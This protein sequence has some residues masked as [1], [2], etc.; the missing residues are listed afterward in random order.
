MSEVPTMLASK[1]LYLDRSSAASAIRHN[2]LDPDLHEILLDIT[3][4]TSL[5]KNLPTDL[6]IELTTFQEMLVS[7]CSRLIRFHP[8]QSLKQKSDIEAVYH[9]GL[10]IFMMT[11]FL[12]YDHRRILQYELVSLRLKDVLDRGLDEVDDDLVLWLLL[13]GGIWISSGTDRFWLTSR[14]M[15]LARRLGLNSWA[16]VHGYVSTFPW[17]STLHDQPGRAVWNSVYEGS[18]MPRPTEFHN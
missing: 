5:V 17:I 11:L 8:L 6:T 12:Q 14:I 15:E 2:G 4:V 13:I 16:D 7:I 10:T 9:I 3:S 1:G 18:Q